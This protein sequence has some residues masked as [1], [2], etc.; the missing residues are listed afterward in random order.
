MIR[1]AEKSN[2]GLM[3]LSDHAPVTVTMLPPQPNYQSWIQKLNP[4]HLF[5]EKFVDYLKEQTDAYFQCNDTNGMDPRTIWEPYKA[6]L[7]GMIIAIIASKKK[8][9]LLFKHIKLEKIISVTTENQ[10]HSSKSA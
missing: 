9:D 5:D 3:T 7:R 1:L 8:K 4:F 10:S 6:F 2:I